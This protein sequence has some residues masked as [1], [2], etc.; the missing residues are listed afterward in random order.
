ML[1][2]CFFFFG[3]GD[4]I[5]FKYWFDAKKSICFLSYDWSLGASLGVFFFGFLH[6]FHKQWGCKIRSFQML[7]KKYCII[8]P[9]SYDFICKCVT[10]PL[11]KKTEGEGAADEMRSPWAFGCRDL[12]FANLSSKWMMYYNFVSSFQV[13]PIIEVYDVWIFKTFI[14]KNRFFNR[15]IPI[16]L[17]EAI[18]LHGFGVI[19]DPSESFTRLESWTLGPEM[20]ENCSKEVFPSAKR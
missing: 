3:G 8:F 7:L 4:Y 6:I 19:I 11:T 20:S 2:V 10:V 9:M 17:S 14:W 18:P 12:F 15:P 1:G 16:D 13:F 5:F